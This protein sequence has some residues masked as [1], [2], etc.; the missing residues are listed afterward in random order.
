M[1][2]CK[3]KLSTSRAHIPFFSLSA[4]PHRSLS[5]ISRRT[6]W[7]IKSVSNR[8]TIKAESYSTMSMSSLTQHSYVH[9]SLVFCVFV[10]IIA[11]M[12]FVIVFIRSFVRSFVSHR[13]R[14]GQIIQKKAHRIGQMQMKKMWRRY[15]ECDRLSG[16]TK[17]CVHWIIV[18]KIHFHFVR[19][20]KMQVPGRPQSI[21]T[22][23]TQWCQCKVHILYI[24]KWPWWLCGVHRW[25]W[26]RCQHIIR[27][28]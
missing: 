28:H 26:W 20:L 24:R 8:H 11:Q 12:V 15:S 23:C 3:I 9:F 25:R 19:D 21:F 13:R 17:W 10:L 14:W 1:L 27:Y 16:V 6:V 18:R 5:P 4:P 22:L 7:I 2:Q